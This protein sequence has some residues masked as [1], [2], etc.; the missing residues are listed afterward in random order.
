M[1]KSAR[2]EEKQNPQRV[3]T[4]ALGAMKLDSVDQGKNTADS[5]LKIFRMD[6]TLDK[7]MVHITRL[8]RG[9]TD[10]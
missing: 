4:R 6:H 10:R 1:K 9:L 3:S 7:S 5:A 8:C 2:N